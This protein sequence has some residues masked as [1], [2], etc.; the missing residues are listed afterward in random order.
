MKKLSSTIVFFGSGPVAA[1]S[2]ALLN[3][4][5]LIE[6]VITKPKKSHHHGNV[7]VVELAEKIN[8]KTY[9]ASNK[10]ELEDI[11][12]NNIFTSKIAI[13]IDYGIIISQNIIDYFPLGII[14][15]HFSIL[16]EWRG[17]DPI[18]FSVLS[19]QSTTGVSLM[20]IVS[21]MDEGPL[22]AWR[23]SKLSKE[24][25]TPRLTDDLIEL[26]DQLINQ[27]IPL[28]LG[29]GLTLKDQANTGKKTSYSKK[30]TKEDGYIDASNQTAEAIERQIRAFM[31]W[32]KS[33]IR[34]GDIDLII[35]SGEVIEKSGSP[36][37]FFIYEKYLAVN[38]QEKSLK[39]L[40]LIPAGRKKMSSK[41][42][43]IGQSIKQL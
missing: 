19:G 30:I 42:F 26:S 25:T 41:N 31:D 29:N 7:P 15:S 4:N 32:P 38:C 34:F 9:L 2:L 14:N 23:E 1:K 10:L 13:L 40:E 16:P 35:T 11:F 33:K 36:G 22:L 6:A 24:I 20:K 5:F 43:L 27:Y 21:K 12:K 8:I 18:T 37:Q 28:Y 3:K 17:P 39:I